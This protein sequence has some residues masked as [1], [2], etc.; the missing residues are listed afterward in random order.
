MSLPLGFLLDLLGLRRDGGSRRLLRRI[1]QLRVQV[2]HQH[3]GLRSHGLIG[4]LTR[5]A[6]NLLPGLGDQARHLQRQLLRCIAAAGRQRKH[7]NVVLHGLRP[8]RMSRSQ[9]FRCGPIFILGISMPQCF[10]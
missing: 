3:A 2:G 7:A 1:R 6:Q 8:G 4:A 5:C 10:G 9:F